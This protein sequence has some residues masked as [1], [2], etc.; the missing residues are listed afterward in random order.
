M[1][2]GP[3]LP[4]GLRSAAEKSYE[5][6]G[7]EDC[8]LLG[9]ETRLRIRKSGSR[10]APASLF[11]PRASPRG[12]VLL[13]CSPHSP[14]CGH[15]RLRDRRPLVGGIPRLA[16]RGHGP[17]F[18]LWFSSCWGVSFSLLKEERFR[19]QLRGNRHGSG[20]P[21]LVLFFFLISNL[22]QGPDS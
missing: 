3:R 12:W 9:C 7:R 2:A 10:G 11:S 18:L 20:E 19:S 22:C 1:S 17:R 5:S 4:P 21:I 15:L 14:V 6:P 8:G 13:R 16:P